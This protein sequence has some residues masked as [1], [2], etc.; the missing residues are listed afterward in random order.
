MDWYLLQINLVQQFRK[1]G[2]ALNRNTF[3]IATERTFGSAHLKLKLK[4]LCAAVDILFGPVIS[5]GNSACKDRSTDFPLISIFS[6]VIFQYWSL[7]ADML[8][9]LLP[10]KGQR[11]NAFAGMPAESLPI[12]GSFQVLPDFLPPFFGRY[13]RKTIEK[14]VFG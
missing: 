3:Y 13:G 1:V 11:S 5:F 10:V 8:Q 14:S 9:V 4:R 2:L 7:S 12:I 6:P